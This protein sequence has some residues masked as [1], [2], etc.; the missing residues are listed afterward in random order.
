MPA[1]AG[2][3]APMI[4]LLEHLGSSRRRLPSSRAISKKHLAKFPNPFEGD[5]G[6]VE[7]QRILPIPDWQDVHSPKADA[8]ILRALIPVKRGSP[9]DR[10]WKPGVLLTAHRY[11]RT[12]SHPSHSPSNDRQ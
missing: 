1:L 11:G 6:A 5:L 9:F 3:H 8:P 12:L 10:D 2:K 4:V 7:S